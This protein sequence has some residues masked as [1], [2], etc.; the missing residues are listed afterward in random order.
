MQRLSIYMGELCFKLQS[1]QFRDQK[2]KYCGNGICRLYN[3]QIKNSKPKTGIPS[4]Q[5]SFTRVI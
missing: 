5:F 1:L 3:G 4:A 2:S